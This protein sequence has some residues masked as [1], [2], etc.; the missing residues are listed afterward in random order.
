VEAR[1]EPG[2][3]ATDAQML[4]T[5]NHF[6]FYITMACDAST[7]RGTFNPFKKYTMYNLRTLKSR[8]TA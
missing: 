5:K 6:M 7:C 4:Q 2:E 1:S 8:E 3:V